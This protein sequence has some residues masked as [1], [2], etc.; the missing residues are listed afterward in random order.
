MELPTPN[1][2]EGAGKRHD[3]KDLSKGRPK[4]SIAAQIKPIL[5][6]LKTLPRTNQS[7]VERDRLK[8]NNFEHLEDVI[9]MV[10]AMVLSM[11]CSRGRGPRPMC[12]VVWM[13]SSTNAVPFSIA[14]PALASMASKAP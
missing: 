12:S 5:Q 7:S 14:H 3:V 9:V 10:L 4:R 13:P 11:T 1:V 6:I 8:P 2:S